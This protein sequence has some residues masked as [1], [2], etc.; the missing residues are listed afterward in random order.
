MEKI[1]Y[2]NIRK[3]TDLFCYVYMIVQ[4]F[5]ISEILLDLKG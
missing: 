1:L 3:K 2:I 4:L 5:K